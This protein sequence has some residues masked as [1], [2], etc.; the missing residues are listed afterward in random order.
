MPIGLPLPYSTRSAVAPSSRSVKP[1]YRRTLSVSGRIRPGA[2]VAI[3]KADLA[4]L[5]TVQRCTAWPRRRI[6]HGPC[7]IIAATRI[8]PAQPV[9]AP[10]AC[11]A[12]G[13]RC[14]RPCP[15]NGR[16]DPATRC[17]TDAAKKHA[18]AETWH[19]I[20]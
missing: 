7:I 11:V 1:V 14:K 17:R 2:R 4:R 15:D 12:A 13:L 9:G 6:R 16:Q 8:R 18:A 20:V 5:R 19:L 10:L 3:D